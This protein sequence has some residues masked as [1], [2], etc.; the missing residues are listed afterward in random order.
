VTNRFVTVGFEAFGRWAVG[1]ALAVTAVVG[2]G[3]DDDGD[4]EWTTVRVTVADGVAALSS[5]CIDDECRR[6]D[7]ADEVRT[8][9]FA[10]FVGPDPT[11]EILQTG[12]GDSGAGGT[13]Q[14]GGCMLVEITAART[15]FGDCG[16]G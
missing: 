14:A 6:F 15:D 10:A 4:A 3:G 2:C 12:Q 1:A 13:V 5:I 8:A 11:F 16:G 9:E 7:P